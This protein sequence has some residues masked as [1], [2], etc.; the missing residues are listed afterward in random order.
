MSSPKFLKIKTILV[1]SDPNHW[2]I[3]A[4]PVLLRGAL[5]IVTNVGRVAVDADVATDERG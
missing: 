5:A 1:P 2:H 4:H 3:F